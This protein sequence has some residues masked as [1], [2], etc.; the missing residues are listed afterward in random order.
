[1]RAVFVNENTLGHTSYLPRF[2]RA[3][4]QIAPPDWECIQL[5]AT[6]LPPELRSAERGFRGLNR[7]G[8]DF[9]ASRWRKALCT[10]VRQQLTR[11]A[12]G[13]PIDALVVN[14]QSAGLTLP[15]DFP[16]VPTFVALDATFTQLARSPWFTPTPPAALFHPLTLHWLR[17]Q[18]RI[19]FQSAAQ[20]LPWSVHAAD[21]LRADYGIPTSRITLLP[22]SMELPAGSPREAPSRP[23]PRILFI[24]GDF[25]RKGGPVL[26][27]AWRTQLREQ[28]DLH[29]VTRSRV[30]PEPG[31]TL[32][33]GVEAG[34][35]EWF[36]LWNTADV[37]AFPSRLETFGIVLIEAMAFGV[38]IVTSDAGAARQLLAAPEPGVLLSEV[39]PTTLAAALQ[40]VLGDLNLRDQ[41]SRNGRQ[42]FANDFQLGANARRLIQVV[43]TRLRGSQPAV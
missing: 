8:L 11:I 19:L 17:H 29:V 22:P 23:R 36:G 18:E 43:E 16:S 7:L 37:F 35:P 42:R 4:Q 41:L 26:L 25:E 28:A 39:T 3:I 24:G 21:S 20:L 33:A 32:H 14:T 6:P 40:Q 15:Q 5:D 38:P 2:V 31:L 34:S 1:M 30:T 27:E 12:A 10:H 13:R 9:L